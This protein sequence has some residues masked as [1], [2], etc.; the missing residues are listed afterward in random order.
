MTQHCI[1]ISS[2]YSRGTRIAFDIISKSVLNLSTIRNTI[3][4]IQRRCGNDVLLATHCLTIEGESWKSVQEYDP[5]FADVVCFASLDDFADVINESRVLSGIDVAL[6]I[7]SK[8]KCTHLQLQKL[9]YLAYADYL[10]SYSDKL[11]SDKI[12]A[13]KYGPIIDSV[14][15]KYKHGEKEIINISDDTMIDAGISYMSIKNRILF[16]CGGIRKLESIDNTLKKYSKYS[17][18]ELVSITHRD[19]APWTHCDHSQ[20]YT[21]ITDD[22]IKMYHAAESI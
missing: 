14:Y 18:N 20:H 11:F 5:F 1:I 13:F 8:I 9:V 17:A 19:G 6:Y 21:E 10:C 7:L 16:A 22:V 12:Y 4:Y 2:A 15:K 3:E